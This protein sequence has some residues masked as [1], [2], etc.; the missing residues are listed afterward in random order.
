MDCLVGFDSMS[1][2]PHFKEDAIDPNLDILNYA[3]SLMNRSNVTYDLAKLNQLSNGPPLQAPV[4]PDWIQAE[5]SNLNDAGPGGSHP[6]GGEPADVSS[7]GGESS[8]LIVP[9]PGNELNDT[10][11]FRVVFAFLK[12]VA[13]LVSLLSGSSLP[14][15]RHKLYDSEEGEQEAFYKLAVELLF[16]PLYHCQ[17]LKTPACLALLFV[18]ETVTKSGLLRTIDEIKHYL[19]GVAPVGPR[20]CSD[21]NVM[22][23]RSPGRPPSRRSLQDISALCI[24][25]GRR[26]P[27][28]STSTS[29]QDAQEKATRTR[30]LG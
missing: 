9:T 18:A 20:A 27:L 22:A 6:L 3:G 25:R 1:L 21:P 15:R 16:S 19:S 4:F 7:V 14:S 12:D 29:Q 26:E 13:Q 23:D 10:R 17:N 24:V 30:I 11:M 28:S 8:R 2:D 5:P